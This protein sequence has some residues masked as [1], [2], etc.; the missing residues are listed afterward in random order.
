M[1]PAANNHSKNSL[2]KR[3]K[4]KSSLEIEAL[5]HENQSIVSFPIKCFFSFSEI[6]E[7]LSTL[8]VAFAV[9]KRTFKLATNR[10]TIKRRMREAYRLNYKN[11][12]DPFLNQQEKQ[13]KLFMIYMGKE[14]LEYAIIE[15][16]MQIILNRLL[17]TYNRVL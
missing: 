4:L 14:I 6:K 15:Q 5:Y 16:N 12:L 3:D 2:A 1:P 8:R 10:N 13:M 9:S 17:I 11:I 7:N